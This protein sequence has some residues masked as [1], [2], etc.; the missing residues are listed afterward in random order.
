M[1]KEL[2]KIKLK[3]IYAIFVKILKFKHFSR[4]QQGH[5][6]CHMNHSSFIGGNFDN[7]Y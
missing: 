5:W 7:D 2:K 1:L 4:L 6:G 3:S